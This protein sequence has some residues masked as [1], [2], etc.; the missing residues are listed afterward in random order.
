MPL[1]AAG[2]DLFEGCAGERTVRW[3]NGD[4]TRAAE[5]DSTQNEF[6]GVLQQRVSAAGFVLTAAVIACGT[7]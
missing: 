6:H 1:I 4:F 2:K 3:K 7:T 5:K